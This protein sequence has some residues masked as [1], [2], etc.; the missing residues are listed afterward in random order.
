[1]SLLGQLLC[2]GTFTLFG[3]S[4]VAEAFHQT[5]PAYLFP[6]AFILILATFGVAL[7]DNRNGRSS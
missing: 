7:Y 4:A 1:M 3:I 2:G 5:W 6:V